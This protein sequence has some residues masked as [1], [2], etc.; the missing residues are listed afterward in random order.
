MLLHSSTELD[1]T[2]HTCSAQGAIIEG[3]FCADISQFW[4]AEDLARMRRS[5]RRCIWW[6]WPSACARHNQISFRHAHEQFGAAR[7]P[8]GRIVYA[9]GYDSNGTALSWVEVFE[10]PG[11]GALDTAWTWRQ[12]P[13]MSM[14]R[15]GC[16]GC[17]LSDGRFAVLGGENNDGPLSAC[18]ALLVGDNEEI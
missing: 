4:H 1:C 3:R 14:A 8:A 13:A 6:I 11:Q 16:R 9:R 10:P 12:K 17:V 15:I 2:V 5:C 7:L 18:E